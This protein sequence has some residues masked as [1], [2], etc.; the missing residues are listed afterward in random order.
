MFKNI[1]LFII[2]CLKKRKGTIP[3]KVP[4]PQ[5]NPKASP[6]VITLLLFEYIRHLLDFNQPFI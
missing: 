5:D 2:C 3:S 1:K 6:I 4:F